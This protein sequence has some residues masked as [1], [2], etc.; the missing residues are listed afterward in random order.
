MLKGYRAAFINPNSKLL[1]PRFKFERYGRS[2]TELAELIPHT[3]AICDDIAI[4]KSMV[5]DAFNHAPGQL[6]MNTGTMQ[7]GR[8]SMGAWLTL[9]SRIRDARSAGVRRV[10]LRHQR[11]ERRG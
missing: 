2:G 4:V 5:T 11:P 9:R 6:L 8:P 10:Q 1:G 3:G 7:F